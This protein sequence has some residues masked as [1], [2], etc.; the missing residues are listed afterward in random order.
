MWRRV[1]CD[2]VW[3]VG[4][5]CVDVVDFVAAVVFKGGANVPAIMA[6]SGPGA[7]LGGFVVCQN[8]DARWGHWCGLEVKATIEVFM[9]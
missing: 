8:F 3:G 4:S 5:L 2:C 1:E 6:V 9:G 7:A